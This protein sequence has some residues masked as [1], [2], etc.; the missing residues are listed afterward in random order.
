MTF[1]VLAEAAAEGAS[2]P[3]WIPPVIGIVFFL[4]AFL[5]VWSYRDVANRHREKVAAKDAAGA[6]HGAHTGH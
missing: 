5:I 2:F 3:T 4:A 6:D 1:A